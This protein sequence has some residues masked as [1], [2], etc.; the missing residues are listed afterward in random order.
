L[1]L[2]EEGEMTV[3]FRVRSKSERKNRE[4]NCTYS[5]EV[6]VCTIEKVD[7]SEVEDADDDAGGKSY[8]DASSALDKIAAAL[9]G[10]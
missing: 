3:T 7:G 10:K 9:K 4:G 6:E 8:D 1:D 2:P 5:Y